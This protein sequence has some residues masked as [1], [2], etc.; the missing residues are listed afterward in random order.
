MKNKILKLIMIFLFTGV[1]LDLVWA[2]GT[3][4]EKEEETVSEISTETKRYLV[5]IGQRNIGFKGINLE[6]ETSS[7]AFEN[8]L[9]VNKKAFY[10]TA[11]Y[12]KVLHHSK[13]KGFS[14]F[15]GIGGHF[16]YNNN[17]FK[18]TELA[19]KKGLS[20]EKGYRILGLDFVA[21]LSYKL[22]GLP[23]KISADLKPGMDLIVKN[24]SNS[25]HFYKDMAGL[26]ISYQF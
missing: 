25:R 4:K 10:Y 7:N 18:Q 22:P 15:Y 26:T 5:S 23:F 6:Y 13:V 24:L 21:G 17:E 12:K 9:N 19:K 3:E 14:A 8:I 2:N 1:S 16:Y 11:I 20:N